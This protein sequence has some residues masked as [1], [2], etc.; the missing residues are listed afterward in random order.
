MRNKIAVQS[1]AEYSR[2]KTFDRSNTEVK[3]PKVYIKEDNDFFINQA[4]KSSSID[5]IKQ[6]KQI[7]TPKSETV[8]IE[9]L[10][11]PAKILDTDIKT[12]K[13]W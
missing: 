7:K 5:S 6:A 11:T 8:G 4:P 2:M 13:D 3:N 12:I 9:D 10:T 1:Q